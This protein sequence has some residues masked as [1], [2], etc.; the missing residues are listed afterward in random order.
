MQPM[1]ADNRFRQGGRVGLH[2]ILLAQSTVVGV[3]SLFA[4]RGTAAVPVKCV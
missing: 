3:V 1:G 4:L 2:S